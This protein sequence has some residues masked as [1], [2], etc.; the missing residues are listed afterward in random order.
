M[1]G[2]SPSHDIPIVAAVDN[3]EAGRSPYG[4][5]HMAGSGRV[6]QQLVR[7]RLLY[8][9]A[10]SEPLG[11]GYRP[12]QSGAR[13]VMEERARLAAHGHQKRSLAG[14]TNRDHRISLRALRTITTEE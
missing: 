11:T 2:Q 3:G 13:R 5:H 1:F 9:H 4:L 8:D 7:D 10:G 12:L 6:G 14:P